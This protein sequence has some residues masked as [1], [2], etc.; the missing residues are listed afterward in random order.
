MLQLFYIFFFSVWDLEQM[1]SVVIRGQLVEYT[2]AGTAA[3]SAIAPA[4]S[5]LNPLRLDV[6]GRSTE[7]TIRTGSSVFDLDRTTI[8]L[9]DGHLPPR[10]S[11][12][13]P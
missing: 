3:Q 12:H 4:T 6:A 7:N 10:S 1:G 9:I 11:F 2:A 5:T 13:T 8:S